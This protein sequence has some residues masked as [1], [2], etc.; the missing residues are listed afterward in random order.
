MGSNPV[1]SNVLS[2]KFFFLKFW[3]FFER[4]RDGWISNGMMNNESK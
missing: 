1:C 4:R 2:A 3:D